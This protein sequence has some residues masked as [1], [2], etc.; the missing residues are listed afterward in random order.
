MN[1]SRKKEVCHA[2]HDGEHNHRLCR[3]DLGIRS[4]V[5]P[6][7]VRRSGGKPPPAKYRGQMKRRFPKR[8]YGQR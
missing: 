3:E 5:I 1:R 6:L 8:V 4:S 2:L 7:N